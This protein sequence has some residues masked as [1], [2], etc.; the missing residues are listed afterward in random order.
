MKKLLSVLLVL[1]MVASLFVIVPTAD[2]AATE[3]DT[4]AELA[5]IANTDGNYVLTADITLTAALNLGAFN[6]T[7]DGKGH[8][9]D[10]SAVTATAPWFD[11]IGGTNNNGS[12][13]ESNKN[14]TV[15]N[16]VIVGMKVEVN[17]AAYGLVYK[18]YG[19]ISNITVNGLTLTNN[20]NNTS[21][22]ALIGDNYNTVTGV[23]VT[24]GA[25]SAPSKRA[26]G[27]VDINKA[28]AVIEYCTFSG[29][30][31]AGSENAAGITTENSGTVRYCINY[32]EITAGSMRAAGIASANKKTIEN[33]I[34]YGDVTGHDSRVGGISAGE[35][36]T[37]NTV[38]KNCINYGTLTAYRKNNL[39]NTDAKVAGIGVV[40][41]SKYTIENC[42][43]AGTLITSAIN[44]YVGNIVVAAPTVADTN[45]INCYGVTGLINRYKDTTFT[46]YEV[47]SD[48][49]TT[50]DNDDAQRLGSNGTI[51]T[52][53][54]FA[55]AAMAE[56]LGS[57]FVY[58]GD[59]TYPIALAE[60]E[61]PAYTGNVGYLG[62]AGM[63]SDTDY[64]DYI[65]I[66]TEADLL[67]IADDYCEEKLVLTADITVSSAWEQVEWFAG[68]LD[69]NGH[70]ITLTQPSTKPMFDMLDIYSIVKNLTIDGIN[71][72]GGI[73][74]AK[75]AEGQIWN[76]NFTNAKMVSS[77]T[78]AGMIETNNGTIAHVSCEADVTGKGDR[79]SIFVIDNNGIIRYCASFGKVDSNYHVGGI[80]ARNR[81]TGEIYSCLNFATIIARQSRA[82]GI[83]PS[84]S[85]GNK[86]KNC[87]NYGTCISFR[88]GNATNNDSKA[89]GIGICEEGDAYLIENCFNAGTIIVKSTCVYVGGISSRTMNI[90]Q[91]VKNCYS[92]ENLLN[93]YTDETYTTYVLIDDNIIDGVDELEAPLDGCSEN[94]SGTVVTAAEFASAEMVTKLGS[95]FVLNTGDD[96]S[97]Y[98][99]DLAADTE[100]EP[101]PEEEEDDQGGQQGGQQGGTTNPPASGDDKD[102]ETEPTTE[103][104]T[105][106]TTNAPATTTEEESGCG[107][108]IGVASIGLLAMAAIAPVVLRKK[109]ED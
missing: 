23:T 14:A 66:A 101:M 89:C 55:S 76:V 47:V 62:E 100:T 87:G 5:A 70:T 34:N 83:S 26:A 59:A 67:K 32:G 90:D 38:I 54:E 98:P 48:D 42:A 53:A 109:K 95:A 20:G 25:I 16:L 2:T 52:A 79:A 78:N 103:P 6:G 49:T 68:V 41:K 15:K 51:V 96:A 4:E 108:V 30:V 99:I 86:I 63:A 84:N 64:S 3:I 11:T 31:Y 81:S 88:E 72:T 65:E 37:D 74:F 56:K 77:G 85:A 75:N 97:A 9:I 19:V 43:N 94:T 73:G 36:S 92:V 39:T 24:E 8:K 57:A 60:P 71:T 46:T 33:C 58:T 44:K 61:L 80:V 35:G 91:Y 21:D 7:L 18:S 104:V 69:G 102:N 10:A 45:V 28:N 107:S 40:E 93:R 12:Y 105:E 50:K 1:A 27:I 106:P 13:A 22:A 17:K 82:A 29:T